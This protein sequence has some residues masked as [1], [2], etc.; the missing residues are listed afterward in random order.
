MG[1]DHDVTELIPVRVQER[2]ASSSLRSFPQL[3]SAGISNDHT[4]AAG[5]I[6][7]VVGVVRQLRGRDNLKSCPI[8]DLR[9]TVKSAS[10]EES[11]V[12][13]VVEYPLWLAQICNGA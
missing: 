4:F 8:E 7:N 2:K 3:L 12:G 13:I 6:A 11:I 9:D 1:I 5:V 10:N